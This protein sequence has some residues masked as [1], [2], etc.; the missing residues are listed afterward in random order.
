MKK[1]ILAIIAMGLSASVTAADMETG[2]QTMQWKGKVPVVTPPTDAGYVIEKLGAT[3]FLA[4]NLVFDN[5]AGVV[6]LTSSSKIGFVVK[7]ADE[8]GVVADD[9]VPL[10][11]DVQLTNVRVGINGAPT[12]EQT[13]GFFEV[14]HNNAVFPKNS[15]VNVAVDKAAEGSMLEI[16]TKAG[17]TSELNADEEVTVQAV[18]AV[19]PKTAEI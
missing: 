9:A 4:G 10:A 11:Y 1:T 13:N 2:S 15:T 14:K 18:V 3:D 6:T 16:A 5:T 8:A 7:P 19:T 12:A 17:V